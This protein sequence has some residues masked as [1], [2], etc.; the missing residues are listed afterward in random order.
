MILEIQGKNVPCVTIT[1]LAK[2]CNRKAATLRRM[3]QLKVL[4]KANF[5]TPDIP[6]SGGELRLGFRVYTQELAVKVAEV[7]KGEI[8]QGVSVA[9]STKQKLYDLFKEERN[10]YNLD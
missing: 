7:V 8:T 9:E 3:E 1:M 4:P 10:K 6:L 2:M 5:R